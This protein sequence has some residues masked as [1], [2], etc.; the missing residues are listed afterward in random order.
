MEFTLYSKDGCGDCLIAEMLLEDAK[1]P[2]ICH[3]V[4]KNET[5]EVLVKHRAKKYPVIYC[6]KKFIGSLTELKSVFD[7]YNIV[8]EEDF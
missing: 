2:F 4:H 7:E 1:Q 3:K 8:S 6:N 5:K